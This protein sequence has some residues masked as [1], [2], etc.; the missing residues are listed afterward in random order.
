MGR[1]LYRKEESETKGIQAAVKILVEVQKYIGIVF[2][3]DVELAASFAAESDS[4]ALNETE[5]KKLERLDK[6][7]NKR[8]GEKSEGGDVKRA[9]PPDKSS[10][11]CYK[12]WGWGHYSRDWECP[13]NQK[14]GDGPGPRPQSAQPLQ[15]QLQHQIQGQ[16]WSN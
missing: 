9:G 4:L 16:G 13:L 8:K 6:E 15:L 11:R 14:N 3:K 10:V 5:T 7:R 2:N 1:S 12:C